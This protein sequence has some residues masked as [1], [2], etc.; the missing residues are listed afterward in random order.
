MITI[1]TDNLS[2]SFLINTLL[3]HNPTPERHPKRR[4]IT[5]QVSKFLA[6]KSP[7][8]IFW[9]KSLSMLSTSPDLNNV[10]GI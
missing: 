4:N 10:S 7:I 3:N 2:D 5:P 8:S 9:M 6:L 1:L